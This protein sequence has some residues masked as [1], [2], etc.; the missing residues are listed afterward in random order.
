M[1]V[2][3]IRKDE[4]G[5][6]EWQFG[7]STTDYINAQKQINQDIYTK[8][9]EFKYDAFQALQNGIDW[10]TRL[11]YH[12]QKNILDEDIK[13]LIESVEGVLTISDFVSNQENRHYSCECKI[14]TI[15]SG[16]EYIDFN[17]SI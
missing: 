17:F 5:Y 9:Y 4:N 7:H 6:S 13:A 11:G 14:Y 8:L 1:L 12:N 3:S 16:Q 15:Y 10:R 2:R